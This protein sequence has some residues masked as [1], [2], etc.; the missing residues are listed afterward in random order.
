ML[1]AARLPEAIA[2]IIVAGPVAQSPPEK[3]PNRLVWQLDR[4]ISIVPCSVVSISFSPA[5][6]VKSGC[7]PIA[8]IIISVFILNSE[9]EI[10]IG[11]FLPLASGSPNSILMHLTPTT[12]PA[13]VNIPTG[14]AKK[15]ILAPSFSASSTSSFLPGISS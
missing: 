6:K 7:S 10:G 15:V 14:V 3:T 8:E 12:L 2:S 13:W 5:K 9:P 11:R 1:L 4:S